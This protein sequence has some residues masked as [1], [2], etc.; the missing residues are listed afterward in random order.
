VDTLGGL[1]ERAHAAP[2]AI[3]IST[4]KLRTLLTRQLAL[5]KNTSNAELDQAAAS[6]LGWRDSGLRETLVRADAAM[7]TKVSSREALDI[8]RK[9]DDF[10]AKLNVRSQ[11]RRE[12][13]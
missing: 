9:L 8:V 10:T 12:K 11:I 2:S 6:R 1:Y 3:S 13:T 7:A 5:P 4:M